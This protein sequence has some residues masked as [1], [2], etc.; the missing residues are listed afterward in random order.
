M[1]LI[2]IVVV[3][4]SEYSPQYKPS[5]GLVKIYHKNG[6]VQVVGYW[7]VDTGFSETEKWQWSVRGFIPG[8]IL[9]VAGWV[10]KSHLHCARIPSGHP[11]VTAQTILAHC[12]Q[13]HRHAP[14]QRARVLCK[15]ETTLHLCSGYKHE[16]ALG[17]C[18][19]YRCGQHPGEYLDNGDSIFPTPH[20]YVILASQSM[21]AQSSTVVCVWEGW[22]IATRFHSSNR[23][24][25]TTLG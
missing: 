24:Y 12:Q 14:A 19:G 1:K 4:L 2:Y 23:G 5:W 25:N 7:Q 13:W 22:N 17:L 6:V 8:I 3:F 15:H 10:L 18:S 20:P 9:A 11:F 21:C 16:L